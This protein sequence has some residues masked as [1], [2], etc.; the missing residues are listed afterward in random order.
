MQFDF[1]FGI[2]VFWLIQGL[3]LIW[4]AVLLLNL[5]RNKN[6]KAKIK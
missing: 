6:R 4:G 1:N 3:A 2:G 5:K